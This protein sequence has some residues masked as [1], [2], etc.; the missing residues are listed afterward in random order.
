MV[1]EGRKFFRFTPTEALRIF[2]EASTVRGPTQKE[3]AKAAGLANSSSSQVYYPKLESNG[4]IKPID[5]E[6]RR[7]G[8][9]VTPSGERRY[10]EV[11][12][13]GERKGAEW[14]TE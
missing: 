6:N 4:W 8:F 7:A 12:P 10:R 13:E 1:D 3:F 11:V 14:P 2:R 5:P 9:V